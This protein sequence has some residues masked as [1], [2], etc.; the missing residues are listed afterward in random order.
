VA[1]SCDARGKNGKCAQRLRTCERQRFGDLDVEWEGNINVKETGCEEFAVLSLKRM[2]TFSK[3]KCSL[4]VE[5]LID[6]HLG[7]IPYGPDAPR[8]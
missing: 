7:L 5:W 8:P 4:R 3:I 6:L 1:V 2:F